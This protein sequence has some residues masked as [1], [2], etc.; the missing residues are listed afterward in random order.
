MPFAEAGRQK[1]PSAG[2]GVLHGPC[3]VLFGINLLA[4]AGRFKKAKNGLLK[5]IFKEPQEVLVL[6]LAFRCFGK[7][8]LELTIVSGGR[9]YCPTALLQQERPK[10]R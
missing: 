3:G 10:V 4:Y 7:K 2:N 6:F 8:R 9:G 1:N 5:S